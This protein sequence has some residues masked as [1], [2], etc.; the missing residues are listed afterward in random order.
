MTIYLALDVVLMRNL[1]QHL[2]QVDCQ[3]MRIQRKSKGNVEFSV[4]QPMPRPS[5]PKWVGASLV[6]TICYVGYGAV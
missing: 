5:G 4:P 6:T 2:L 3:S 1:M